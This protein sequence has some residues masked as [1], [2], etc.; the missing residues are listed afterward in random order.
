MRATLSELR[1]EKFFSRDGYT[2]ALEKALIGVAMSAE[3]NEQVDNGEPAEVC[4]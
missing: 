3:A 2:R 4:L 1:C